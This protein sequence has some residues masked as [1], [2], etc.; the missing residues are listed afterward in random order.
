MSGVY[1]GAL[2]VIRGLGQEVK[3]A[4]RAQS[5]SDDGCHG[6]SWCWWAVGVRPDSAN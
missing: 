4:P 3:S 6:W 1:C 2:P 5:V